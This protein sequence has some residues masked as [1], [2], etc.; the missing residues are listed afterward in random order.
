MAKADICFVN[1][2]GELICDSENIDGADGKLKASIKKTML[3]GTSDPR[4]DLIV[5]LT[6]AVQNAPIDDAC[7]ALRS[8]DTVGCVNVALAV[9]DPVMVLFRY[10]ALP[11]NIL[12]AYYVQ[13]NDFKRAYGALKHWHSL[14]PGC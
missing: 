11:G 6:Q 12:A 14:K 10:V 4:V 9:A 8:D 1:E 3:P 5:K 2:Q 7:I 13:Q